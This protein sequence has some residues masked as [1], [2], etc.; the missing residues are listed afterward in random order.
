MTLPFAN[1]AGTGG[2]LPDR[3]MPNEEFEATL[4]TSDA[5]IRERT[6]I[7]RRHIAAEDET[8]ADM[9]EAAARQAI[10]AAGASV[11]DVDLII[12][13]TTTPDKVFPST[14]CILQRRLGLKTVPAIRC[15][16]CLLRIYLRAGCGESLHTDR[17]LAMLPGDWCGDVFAD[18]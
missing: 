12:L 6:G 3:V 4:D 10:D 18:P 7:K 16:C 17:R 11:T 2:Y 1:I 14:A 9:A 13:A 8:T 15:P 5:W